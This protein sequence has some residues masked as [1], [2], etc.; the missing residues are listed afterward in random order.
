MVAAKGSE[1]QLNLQV[2]EQQLEVKQLLGWVGAGAGK[3]RV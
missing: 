3:E 1:L 2:D